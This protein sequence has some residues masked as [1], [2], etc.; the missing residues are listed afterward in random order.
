MVRHWR[1]SGS[2]WKKFKRTS[3]CR[4][5][6]GKTVRGSS[7]GARLGRSTY[8]GMSICSSKTMTILIGIRGL[9]KNGWK[10]VVCMAPM[11][12]KWNETSRSWRTTIIL[13]H[14][15]LGCTQ[16][17][18]K[19]NEII[20][21]KFRRRLE[22]R[23]SAGATE[24]TA[25]KDTLKN[26]LEDISNWQKKKTEQFYKVSINSLLGWPSFQ[27]GGGG[28]TGI[29]WRHVTK[30]TRACDNRLAR[31][32]SYIH[33]TNDHWQSCHVE[34]TVKHRR[35]GSPIRNRGTR[36]CHSMDSIL[37]VE[38]K[39]LSGDGKSQRKFLELSE[40][41][42]V[43]HTDNSLEFGKACEDLSWNHST[44][45]LHRSETNGIAERSVRRVK[46][47]TS[48]V[49]L[50]SSL[51]ENWWADSMEC[52]TYLR[53]IQDLLSDGKTPYERRFGKPFERP[54]IPFGSLV[55]YHPITAK[56]QS[57]IRSWTRTEVCQTRGKVSRSLLYCKKNL[58]RHTCGPGGDCQ[59]LKRLQDQI[60]C[61]QMYGE[62]LVK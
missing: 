39:N 38:N 49:L 21:D 23:I 61:G 35:S 13:D 16:R 52:H 57:R 59:K 46:E 43:V 15:Y 58:S 27:G 8:L 3:I 20:I 50:Q 54:I 9:H 31:L 53:N 18:Y 30:W 45:T 29:V 55:E 51:D 14:V 36:S 19:P 4:A 60:M 28:G 26:A 56:E 17:E 40:K 10:D 47:G 5:L 7:V 22:S 32:I 25:W 44:S 42:K 48:A 41:P 24:K 2:S 1:S 34:N 37:S 12:K 6:V 11:W 33:H 62:K